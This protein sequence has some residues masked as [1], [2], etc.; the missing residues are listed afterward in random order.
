M[1]QK[2]SDMSKRD[3]EPV[4]RWGNFLSP[5]TW[6]KTFQIIKILKILLEY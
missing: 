4:M 3:I 2:I 1:K 5:R 6:L